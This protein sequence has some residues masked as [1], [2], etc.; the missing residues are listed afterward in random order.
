MTKELIIE[1]KEA[2]FPV[3]DGAR[4]MQT[5]AVI[6]YQEPTLPE[7]IE[8]CGDKFM[9]LLRCSGPR[10]EAHAWPME[11]GDELYLHGDSPEEAVARL[12]LALHSPK[13]N[14]T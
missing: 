11:A 4:N 2:G 8:A 7:L 1:L 9:E 13:A 6:N 14:V 12:W 3:R 5:G 10:W